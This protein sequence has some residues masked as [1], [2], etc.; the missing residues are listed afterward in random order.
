M[1]E[2][3]PS[4]DP[5]SLIGK[6]IEQVCFSYNAVILRFENGAWLLIERD[7]EALVDGSWLVS[8]PTTIV[9][10][11]LGTVEYLSLN[12]SG[13]Q[14]KTE[15]GALRMICGEDGYESASLTFPCGSFIT[16]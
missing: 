16:I 11:S 7:I 8:E 2:E 4:K 1:K 12:K 13:I 10:M 15:R 5:G 6:T 9:K 14:L 3:A